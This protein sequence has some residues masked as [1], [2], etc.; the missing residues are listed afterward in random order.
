MEN[1]EEYIKKAAEF[2]QNGDYTVAIKMYGKALRVNPGNK[3]AITGITELYSAFAEFNEDILK[4]CIK[5]VDTLYKNGYYDDAECLAV[6]MLNKHGDASLYCLTGEIC[7]TKNNTDNA[8]KYYSHAIKLN[9]RESSYYFKA[10]I[11]FSVKGFFNEAEDCFIKATEIT[12]DNMMYRYGLAYLYYSN[13]K[14]KQAEKIVDIML[15]TESGNLKAKALKILI[16]L[17]SDDIY[18]AEYI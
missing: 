16:L 17:A 2:K 13:K 3:S 7:F 18:E 11:A 12:P 15:N 6:N 8:V 5:T 9:N 1:I 10:A 14:Y 4:E